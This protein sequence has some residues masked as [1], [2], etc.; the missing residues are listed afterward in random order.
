M[1][2]LRENLSAEKVN[3]QGFKQITNI[4]RPGNSPDQFGGP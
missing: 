1:A 4:K 2:A 3:P